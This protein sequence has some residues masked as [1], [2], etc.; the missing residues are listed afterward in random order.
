MSHHY[1]ISLNTCNSAADNARP[2]T[3]VR[4]E[5]VGS[6]CAT[7]LRIEAHGSSPLL[8]LC[9]KLIEIG[10]NPGLALLAYRGAVL[11]LKVRSIGEAAGLEVNGDGTGFRPV[12]KPDGAS[13][14]RE[15]VSAKGSVPPS[16]SRAPIEGA[17]SLQRVPS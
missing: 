2:I 3:A 10:H 14:A 5:L 6:N 11:A 8:T 4:A 9:R 16:P 15:T 13:P 12:R 7:A 17:S 1:R